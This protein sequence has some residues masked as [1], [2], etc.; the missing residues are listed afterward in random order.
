MF[1]VGRFDPKEESQKRERG[2]Q[3][4]HNVANKTLKNRKRKREKS[5]KK[6]HSKESPSSHHDDDD[7]HNK[8]T[9]HVIAPESQ[10][11]YTGDERKHGKIEE[12]AFDDLE[13]EPQQDEIKSTTNDDDNNEATQENRK[14]KSNDTKGISNIEKKKED[15][16]SNPTPDEIQM[17]IHMSTLPIK[18]AA[19]IW[20]LAP[21]LVSNLERAGYQHFFPIQS[22][23]IPDV[24]KSERYS[25]IRAQ[26]ICC[27]SPTGSGK[28]LAF[29]IPI[30]N[31]LADRQIQRLRALV[32]L[33]SRDLAIQVRDVF[34]FYATGSNLKIGLAIGRSDFAAEQLAL[35]VGDDDST[36]TIKKS[37]GLGPDVA[38]AKQKYLL[39]PGNARIAI[40]AF[41]DLNTEQMNLHQASSQ[42][43]IPSGGRSAVDVL[44]CTPGRLVDHLDN[45]PG[46]TLQ[47]LHFLVVDEADKILS[48]S[49]HNWIGRVTDAAN[50]AS[51]AAWHEI[52][53]KNNS[54]EEILSLEKS[55]DGCSYDI[56][57]ITWRRGGAAGDDSAFSTNDSNVVASVCRPVQLRK[58]LYSATLTRD[59]QKLA[60]LRLVNPKHFDARRLR[61]SGDTTE[62]GSNKYSMPRT[63][64]EYLVECTAEQ[65][66]M[67]LLALIL[68]Q[69]HILSNEEDDDDDQNDE[70]NDDSPKKKKMIAVFTSSVDTTHR[71]TRLLQILWKAADLG[72]VTSS[73]AEFSSSL[74]QSERSQLVSRCGDPNDSLT[75]VVCSDGMSRGLQLDYVAVVVNY[76]VPGFAKTYVHR[77]GRTA[78]AGKKG[79]AISLLKGGQSVQFSKMRQLIDSPERVKPMGIK[80]SLVQSVLPVYRDCLQ[81]LSNVLAAEDSGDLRSTDEIPSSFLE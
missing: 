32:V 20:N 14:E 71:L 5:V 44:V 79:V 76:D 81:T 73:V 68:E 22:L 19:Q 15:D 78:R 36:T 30:L 18:K 31:A 56:N 42:Q 49:Y 77:C 9:L 66:P 43:S 35:T 1:N 46:F 7:N 37:F 59:P 33:P 10:G 54:N 8:T 29:V 62:S 21:F 50:T 48:Q 13:I 2:Q 55:S 26:D 4:D 67:V 63:L 80:K 16:V 53:N 27:A 69:L 52:N 12:E 64:S 39:D 70:D 6:V 45:T 57:M 47:H 11:P 23:V 40:D 51:M 65:K 24:I 58:L 25:Y 38:T 28:T 41:S 60:S 75:V 74:T 72:G 61:E 34:Q 3:G 17:A